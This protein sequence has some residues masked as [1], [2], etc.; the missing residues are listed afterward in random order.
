M[1]AQ[2]SNWS[3]KT[4]S[5]YYGRFKTDSGNLYDEELMEGVMSF[6]K[7]KRTQNQQNTFDPQ[8]Q[9]M[10][11]TK[12]YIRTISKYGALSMDRPYAHTSL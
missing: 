8:V 7:K 6:K 2:K 3:N 12:K 9:R 4:S 1:T 11:N 10:N 5:C